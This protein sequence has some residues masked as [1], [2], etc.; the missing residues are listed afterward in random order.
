M[1]SVEYILFRF[2]ILKEQINF[3]KDSKIKLFVNSRHICCGQGG[4]EGLK[5]RWIV[6]TEIGRFAFFCCWSEG[7]CLLLLSLDSCVVEIE[8]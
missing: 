1:K 8:I 2:L 7:L 6:E 3:Y 4:V 5:K